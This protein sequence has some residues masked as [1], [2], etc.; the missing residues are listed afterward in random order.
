MMHIMLLIAGL[1]LSAAGRICTALSASVMASLQTYTCMSS[2][3]RSNESAAGSRLIR[4]AS[5][6]L[7]ELFLVGYAS[8]Q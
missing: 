1:R 7:R 3:L 2:V 6:S 4:L 5:L 8:L